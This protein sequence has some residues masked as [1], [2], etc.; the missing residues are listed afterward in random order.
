MTA[1]T[2]TE[3]PEP[4]EAPALTV[5]V[6]EADPVEESAPVSIEAVALGAYRL[7]IP[8]P[9]GRKHAVATIDLSGHVMV[10]DRAVLLQPV[11]LE[12]AE[13]V[14]YLHATEGET[15]TVGLLHA[16]EVETSLVLYVHAV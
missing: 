13:L 12:T 6:P 5:D 1:K 3:K 10:R 16:P 4:A 2:T 15:I 7:R 14:P 9:A 11:G 8:V